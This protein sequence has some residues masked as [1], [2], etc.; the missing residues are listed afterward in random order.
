MERILNRTAAGPLPPNPWTTM[1]ATRVTGL[2]HPI[3][4]PPQAILADGRPAERELAREIPL[5]HGCVDLARGEV[6]FEDGD[7]CELSAREAELLRYLVRHAGRVISRDEILAEVWR[8]NPQRVITRTVDMHVAH[9][10]D[11]LR[12]KAG[13]P[14]VLLTVHGE[15][16]LFVAPGE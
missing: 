16:Y 11:K 2:V 14:R 8:L 12:D 4:P 10:R 7:G 15:G 9:L 1:P 6:R 5:P 13:Q 3:F